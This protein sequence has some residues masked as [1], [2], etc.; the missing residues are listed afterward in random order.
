MQKKTIFRVSKVFSQDFI[1]METPSFND[2]EFHNLKTKK[3]RSSLNF[4]QNHMDETSKVNLY[5]AGRNV[6]RLES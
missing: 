1:S 5:L 4:E 3:T 6:V 2:L